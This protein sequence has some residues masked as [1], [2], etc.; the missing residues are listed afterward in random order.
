MSRAFLDNLQ[1]NF[2]VSK[3]GIYLGEVIQSFMQVRHHARRRLVRD[4]DRSLQD[5]L[6]DDV[7][8][9][10]GSR[11][12]TDVEPVRFMTSCRKLLYQFLQF[13]QPFGNQVHILKKEQWY[14]NEPLQCIPNTCIKPVSIK[15]SVILEMIYKVIEQV[16]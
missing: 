2:S 11:L 9:G 4:L 6:R 16:F 7:T 13:G 10:C 15:C 1:H 5:T 8:V 3:Q 12:S 14:P